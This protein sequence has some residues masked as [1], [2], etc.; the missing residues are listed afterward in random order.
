MRLASDEELA[1]GSSW[2][3]RHVPI[4]VA[5]LVHKNGTIGYKDQLVGCCGEVL[6]AIEPIVEVLFEEEAKLLDLS[7]VATP[8][9]PSSTNSSDPW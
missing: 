7:S 2:K 5:A 9:T 3:F 1:L 4:K 8:R 6:T